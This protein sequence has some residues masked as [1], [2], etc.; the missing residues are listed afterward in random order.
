[1][2]LEWFS[3]AH[4]PTFTLPSK[5][6]HIQNILFWNLSYCSIQNMSLDTFKEM[7]KFRQLYLNNNKIVS[8]KNRVFRYLNQL[9]TLDLCHNALQNR[10]ARVFSRLS[11][12]RSLSLCHNNVRRINIT[13][14]HAVVRIGKVDLEGNTWICDCDSANVYSS[15]AKN[16]F[17]SLNLTCEFPDDLKQRF[18]SIINDLEFQNYHLFSD[19]EFVAR[20]RNDHHDVS[21]GRVNMANNVLRGGSSSF[22]ER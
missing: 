21:D 11:E 14:L 19:R 6:F 17:C 7:G 8:L 22:G 16:I 5:G 2:K 3:L 4:N 12:L 1:M 18:W 15:C 20:K 9:Q 13:F 10:D